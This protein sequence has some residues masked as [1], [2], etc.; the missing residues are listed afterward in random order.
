ML[1]ETKKE[2]RKKGGEKLIVLKRDDL[3]VDGVRKKG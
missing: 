2:K 3:K 1:W